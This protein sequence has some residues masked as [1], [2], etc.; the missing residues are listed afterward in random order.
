MPSTQSVPTERV[1]T[2]APLG[3]PR[4]RGGPGRAILIMLLCLYPL[5]LLGLSLLHWLAPQQ[6]GPL[7]LSQV[8][9]PFLYLPG[10]ALV[11]FMLLR[12]AGPLRGLLLACAVVYGLRFM[13]H[14]AL[15]APQADP[16]AAHLEVMSWNVY[17]LNGQVEGLQEFLRSK[18]ADVVALEEFSG[19]WIADDEV[20][21][22]VYPYQLIYPLGC[23]SGVVLLSTYPIVARSGLDTR[24]EIRQMLPMCWARLDLG[25]GR[26]LIFMG[27]H[28][29]S[30]DPVPRACLRGNALCYDTT[31]RDREIAR[32]REQI[33]G[34]L[35]TGEP[36][37]IAGDFNTTEREPAYRDLA[38]G[39]Q[40]SYRTVGSGNGSTWTPIR[41][42]RLGIPL[43][44]IDYLLASPTVTPLGMTTDCTP[45]GSDHC[46]VRGRFEIK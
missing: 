26:T 22:Q 8:L 33:D 30:P 40:D 24:L 32:I 19:R 43:L 4:S 21:R 41:F 10:L 18:P 23:P 28:P 2:P 25:N 5:G 44:R 45:R 31:D 38:A 12:G 46:L 34:F 35:A 29:Q 16:A 17:A 3:R 39:L 6:V 15:T 37:L 27:A 14:V 9:A 1:I 11:P 36:L 42:L 20:L 7:A 13:P